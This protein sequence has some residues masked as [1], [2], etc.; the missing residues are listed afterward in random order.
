M[1]RISWQCTAVLLILQHGCVPLMHRPSPGGT[2]FEWSAH[3]TRPGTP[4]T[5]APHALPGDESQS[6]E[7]TMVTHQKSRSAVHIGIRVDRPDLL[8]GFTR[9]VFPDSKKVASR[10]DPTAATVPRDTP[11]EA[12]E[13]LAIEKRIWKEASRRGQIHHE[14][15]GRGYRED[16]DAEFSQ[17]AIR[18]TVKVT[19]NKDIHCVA[20]RKFYLEVINGDTER[21][22][23]RYVRDFRARVGL[24]AHAPFGIVK[25]R[26]RDQLY[27]QLAGN[28]GAPARLEMHRA[29]SVLGTAPSESVETALICEGPDLRSAKLGRFDGRWLRGHRRVALRFSPQHSI[30]V[31]AYNKTMSKSTTPSRPT[32]A[33]H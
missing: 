24:R 25:P 10:F 12:A 17:H 8:D 9:S 1:G 27:L 32:L 2:G 31:K 20:R 5:Y 14:S 16:N 29:Y 28:S 15:V 11:R 22:I 4:Q 19:L 18:Q 13:W 33:G 7:I 6:A 30:R 3:E 26:I 23:D 21:L